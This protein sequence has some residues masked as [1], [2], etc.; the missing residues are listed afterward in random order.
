VGVA[1]QEFE[2]HY[3]EHIAFHTATGDW[4]RGPISRVDIDD[5]VLGVHGSPLTPAE[6]TVLIMAGLGMTVPETAEHLGRSDPTIKRHRVHILEKLL[7]SNMRHA[8]ALGFDP[9]LKVLSVEKP[10][11][12]PDINPSQDR[13][14]RSIRRGMMIGQIIYMPGYNSNIIKKD[15]VDLHRSP[16]GGRGLNSAG[17]VLRSFMS[18]KR[19]YS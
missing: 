18:D 7:A 16:H 10:I 15:L 2:H 13:I 3:Y 14:V 17:L 19:H 6:T 11:P 8:I 1:V 9:D 4:R 5:G 12:S